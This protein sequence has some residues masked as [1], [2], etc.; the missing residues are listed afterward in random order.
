MKFNVFIPGKKESGMP[1]LT[2]K[3]EASNWLIALKE[4]LKQLG[5]QGDALANIVC[6]TGE[7][8]SM[9]VADPASKRVF[10]IKQ[11]EETEADEAMA[12]EAEERA[13]SSRQA[14]EEAAAEAAEA[15]KKL[16]EAEASMTSPGLSAV[17]VQKAEQE[18]LARNAAE[19]AAHEA[20][21]LARLQEERAK[22]EA[23][24]AAAKEKL[25]SAADKAANEATGVLGSVEVVQADQAARGDE[26]D[27]LDDWYDDDDEPEEQ[28]IDV[29]ISDIFLST[30]HLHEVSEGEAATSVLQLAAKHVD[31]E[32]A[33]VFYSDMNSAL[34]DMIIAAATGPVAKK[35]LGIHVPLGKGIV[36]FSVANGVRLTVNNVNKNPNFYGKLDQE[37]GFKTCNLVCVPILHDDRVYGAIE[38]IN[39]KG[40]G[41][42]TATDSN[43]LEALGKILGRALENRINARQEDLAKA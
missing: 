10:V 7:D 37:F 26:W 13:A 5:E 12:L 34:N 38:M 21:E 28:T 3:V 20:A 8:G 25:T 14:A 30:D 4:S 40:G 1:D 11:A 16:K 43:I 2:V 39:K 27:D 41:D 15:E 29:A 42:W 22:L 36:G 9:R 6:E 19:Q 33:S 32:A 23:E 18:A 24:L 31:A 35:I 17:D